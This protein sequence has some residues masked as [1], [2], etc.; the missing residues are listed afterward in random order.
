MIVFWTFMKK[1]KALNSKREFEP[2]HRSPTMTNNWHNERNSVLENW[3][4]NSSRKDDKELKAIE[5]PIVITNKD[6]KKDFGG[7]DNLKKEGLKT[8]LIEKKQNNSIEIMQYKEDN[9]KNFDERKDYS[10]VVQKMIEVEKERT[11][12]ETKQKKK[13]DIIDEDKEKGMIRKGIV[14]EMLERIERQQGNS[15]L[16]NSKK[17]LHKE[18]DIEKDIGK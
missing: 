10:H 14:K 2:H 5:R 13:L 18:I 7:K 1:M 8:V 16:T 9:K 11:S 4:I 15:T 12:I 6:N 3:H 17:T